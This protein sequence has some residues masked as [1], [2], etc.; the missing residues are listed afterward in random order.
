VGRFED[1]LREE[2]ERRGRPADPTGIYEHLIRRRERRRIARRVEAGALAF[3]VFAA[4]LWGV[5]ALRRS[6]EPAPADAPPAGMLLFQRYVRCADR[7]DVTGNLEVMAIDV[8][9]GELRVVAWDEI[10]P[11][12]LSRKEEPRSEDWPTPSPD[13]RSFAW[14]DRYPNDVLVTDIAT[15]ETRRLTQGLQAYIPRF[16]ADGSTLLFEATEYPP[17]GVAPAGIYTVPVDGSA[18]PTFLGRGSNPTWTNDGRIAFVRTSDGGAEGTARFYVTNADGTGEEL[19][20]EGPGDVTFGR[21]E[22]SPDGTRVVADATVRGNTDIYVLDLETQIPT[23][24]TDAPAQDTSPTWSPD[25]E[26]IAFHTGRWGTEL[27]HA[28]LA[29]MRADGSSLQRLTNDCWGDFMPTWI[30][31]DTLI[32][33]LPVY[34]PPPIPDLGE[35]SAADP[36]DILISGTVSGYSDLFGVDPETGEVRNLTADHAEQ[37]GAAWSPDHTRI[38][39]TGDLDDDESSDLYVMDRDGGNLVQLTDTPAYE[40]RPAWSPDG[41]RIAFEGDDGVYVMNTDGSDAHHLAGS[42]STGGVYPTWSPDSSQI[43]YIQDSEIWVV[44]ADGSDPHLVLENPRERPSIYAY[45]VVWSPDGSRLLFTCERDLCL[46][47]PDG[48]DLF[49]LTRGSGLSYARSADWS[50]DGTQIVFLGFERD[51]ERL[52]VMGA[53]GSNIRPLVE[54]QDWGAEPDW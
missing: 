14:V 44:N 15:G 3:A 20:F 50:P 39:F 16:S 38:V 2:L 31:D 54:L 7:P 48:S 23:R 47:D 17:V 52:Y 9:T 19:V 35:P 1:R 37:W 18:E 25:G 30:R 26:W 21:A 28:E 27:G 53:D 40:G 6:L 43:A 24:L 34:T 33:S 46:V 22:W 5:F 10:V 51:D 8:T 13:G 29:I 32:R 45:E 4:S 42:S 12:A 11:G 49:E 41:T 36:D